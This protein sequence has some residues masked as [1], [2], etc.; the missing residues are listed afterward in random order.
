MSEAITQFQ[1]VAHHI[2]NQRIKIKMPAK[3]NFNVGI[4]YSI[5]SSLYKF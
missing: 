4:S 3:L 5:E 1:T 2:E